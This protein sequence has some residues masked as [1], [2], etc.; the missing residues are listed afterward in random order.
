L[1]ERLKKKE[2]TFA[3]EA[4][5]VLKEFRVEDTTDFTVGKEITIDAF[6]E[7]ETIEIAGTSKGRGFAGVAS[8]RGS[9]GGRRP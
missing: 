8:R 4:F 9:A 3:E 2:S 6:T 1:E 7:G 5:K